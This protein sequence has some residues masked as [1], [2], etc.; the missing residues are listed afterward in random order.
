M[1]DGTVP[2]RWGRGLNWTNLLF[3]SLTP[4]AAALGVGL[5]ARA[6]GVAPGDLVAFGAMMFLSAVAIIPGYHRYFAHRSYRASRPLQLFYLLIA[7]SGFHQS[8]LVWASEHRDH[9]KY[10]DTDRDPY[11]VKDGFWWAQIGWILHGKTRRRFANIPDLVNDPLLRW[12]DRYWLP[13]GILAGF[14]LPAL[15]GLAF[16]RPLGGLLWGGLLRLVVFQHCTFLIN[17]AAH[18]VGSRPYIVRQTARNSWWLDLLTFGEGH[19]NFHHAFPGDYRIGHQ[20]WHFDPAKWWIA[21]MRFFGL[22][23]HLHR[24]PRAQIERAADRLS[25]GGV[26]AGHAAGRDDHLPELHVAGAEGAGAL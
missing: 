5:Y 6:Y 22:A 11:N 26:P 10:V 21:T 14:G 12:Q 23:S 16:G 3:F 15:I 24:T 9:H 17:S 19:H 13:L 4:L 1:N 18:T 2:R 7:P 8:A 25:D 20:P